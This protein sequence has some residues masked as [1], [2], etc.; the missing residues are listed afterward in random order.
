MV[1]KWS[2]LEAQDLSLNGQ[3]LASTSELYHFK[4]FRKT[5]RFKKF[6]KGITCMV[7]KNYARRKHRT[8]WLVLSYI[9]KSWVTSYLKM[10]QFERFYSA[11]GRFQFDAFSSNVSVFS[12]KL[13]SILNYNGINITSCSKNILARHINQSRGAGFL[14]NPTKNNNSA[15]V[16][17][18]CLQ[19]ITLSTD[20]YPN[21]VN[22]NNSFYPYS[23]I[24][25][26]TTAEAHKQLIDTLTTS[27]FHTTLLTN[28]TMYSLLIN[29]TLFNI[30]CTNTL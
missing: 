25:T 15:I 4:V 13:S 21:L 23:D 28:T 6:N 8:N 30:K 12:L 26:H 18:S 14:K 16:Q 29:L 10:R 20:I 22:I 24:I 11:L 7:R 3:S 9:T 5:T 2:Y 17:A 19:D 27:I 1:R